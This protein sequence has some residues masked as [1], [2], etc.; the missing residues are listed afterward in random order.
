VWDFL[1]GLGGCEGKEYGVI[2]N[3]MYAGDAVVGQ[4]RGELDKKKA[5]FKVVAEEVVRDPTDPL[6]V[7]FLYMK[8][9]KLSLSVKGNQTPR[10][11]AIF[12]PAH[13][14]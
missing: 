7:P 1:G 4:I 13:P 8:C 6:S 3:Y 10:T 12:A 14:P 11:C 9:M 2:V 5:G